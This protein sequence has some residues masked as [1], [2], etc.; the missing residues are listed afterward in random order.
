MKLPDAWKALI[1]GF[2]IGDAKAKIAI[3]TE[4]EDDVIQTRLRLV[5]PQTGKTGL[6]C[7]F[8]ERNIA[9]ARVALRAPLVDEIPHHDLN[10]WQDI[11]TAPSR[12]EVWRASRTQQRH[13]YV[14]P[15]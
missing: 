13:L 15:P 5:N 7:S 8:N 2:L 11:V 10:G 6:N 14:W 12:L 3:V 4:D 1:T 9:A